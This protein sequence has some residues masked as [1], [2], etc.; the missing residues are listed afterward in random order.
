MVNSSI[1]VFFHEVEEKLSIIILKGFQDRDSFE[2]VFREWFLY[3][4]NTLA[5]LKIPVLQKIRVQQPEL[6]DRINNHREALIRDRFGVL[7]QQARDKGLLDPMISIDL[8]IQ[9]IT[10]LVS[11]PGTEEIIKE[12]GSPQSVLNFMSRLMINGILN[13]DKKGDQG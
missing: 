11:N 12:S 4:G 8:I 10:A 1:D 6:W 7:L 9:V 3:L 5:R 2:E 13:R